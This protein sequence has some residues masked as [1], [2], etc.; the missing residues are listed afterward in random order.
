MAVGHGLGKNPPAAAGF[1]FGPRGGHMGRPIK[2][3]PSVCYAGSPAKLAVR[4]CVWPSLVGWQERHGQKPSKQSLLAIC[5]KQVAGLGLQAWA[6]GFRPSR[7]G[8]QVVAWYLLAWWCGDVAA[9]Y[10]IPLSFFF[11]IP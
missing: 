1:E 4:V 8:I 6:R 9:P 2:S 3:W 10:P 7:R 5:P 11:Q